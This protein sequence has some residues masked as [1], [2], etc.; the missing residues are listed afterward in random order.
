MGGWT[1]AKGQGTLDLEEWKTA[2][3]NAAHSGQGTVTDCKP[4]GFRTE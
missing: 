4:S 1:A 2:V 3:G